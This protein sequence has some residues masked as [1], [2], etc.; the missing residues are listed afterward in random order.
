[1]KWGRV[2]KHNAVK[3]HPDLLTRLE[4]ITEKT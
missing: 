2:L 4:N 1:M 3:F